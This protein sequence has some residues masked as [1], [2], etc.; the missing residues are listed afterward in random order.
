[1]TPAATQTIK[2]VGCH[3]NGAIIRSPY[4]TQLHEQEGGPLSQKK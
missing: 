4:L 1:M 3:D 2:R